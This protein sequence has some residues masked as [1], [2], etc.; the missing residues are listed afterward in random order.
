MRVGKGGL[1]TTI[2]KCTW[3][4][5]NWITA[6]VVVW[7]GLAAYDLQSGLPGTLTATSSARTRPVTRHHAEHGGQATFPPAIITPS[8]RPERSLTPVSAA[9]FNPYAT[10]G[11]GDHA[12]LAYR[13]IDGSRATAWQT[14]WYTTP[15]MGGLYRGTGLLVDMGRVVTI[16]SVRIMLGPARG[17][18]FRLRIG[19]TP[20]L[21]ALRSVASE[22]DVGGVVRIRLSAPARGRYV[23]I[24]FT[25]LPADGSGTFQANVYNLVLRGQT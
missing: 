13:A 24:W 20:T 9:A 8:V 22:T 4:R 17:A 6:I 19:A 23:L 16:A 3:L 21:A 15:R 18:D 12:G 10:E 7:A 5:L 1:A 2:R 14:D 11:R 25:G